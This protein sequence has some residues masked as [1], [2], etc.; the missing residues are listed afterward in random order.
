MY[1]N[2]AQKSPQRNLDR[3]MNVREESLLALIR[4]IFAVTARGARGRIMTYGD[5][6]QRFM[7]KYPNMKAIG[8]R[9]LIGDILPKDGVG[10]VVFLENGDSLVYVL[11]PVEED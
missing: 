9:P 8:Y 10:I 2:G 3:C 4:M 6:Y 1:G 7:E 5:I 11:E